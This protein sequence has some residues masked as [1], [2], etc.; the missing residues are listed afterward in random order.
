MP[1]E[2]S[3]KS[4]LLFTPQVKFSLSENPFDGLELNY[5]SRFL[6]K[7][8]T[9]MSSIMWLRLH[10]SDPSLERGFWEGN[11]HNIRSQLTFTAHNLSSFRILSVCVCVSNFFVP[12]LMSC[13]HPGCS[14]SAVQRSI[15]SVKCDGC[16]F[17]ETCDP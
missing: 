6:H 5:G 11:G 8:L 17:G 16:S 10:R 14:R 4:N 15:R 3:F 2:V 13:H 9:V 1:D 12:P 7:Y